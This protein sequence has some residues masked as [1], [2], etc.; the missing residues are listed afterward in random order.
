MI[1]AGF[2]KGPAVI[3]VL[4]TEFSGLY[5][6]ASFRAIYVPVTIGDATSTERSY[7]SIDDEN[8][9]SWVISDNA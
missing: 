8:A 1:P 2:E 4:I 3:K 7:G 9:V 6:G 5:N